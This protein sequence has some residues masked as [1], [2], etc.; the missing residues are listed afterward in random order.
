L[1]KVLS[2]SVDVHADG[3]YTTYL[4]SPHD[5]DISDL[6]TG[7]MLLKY[8]LIDTVVFALDPHFSFHKLNRKQAAKMAENQMG[9]GR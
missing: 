1:D 5:Q 6:C 4:I 9:Y 3:A 8:D 7:L 2:L